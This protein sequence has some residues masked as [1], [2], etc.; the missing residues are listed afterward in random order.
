MPDRHLTF[1]IATR[2]RDGVIGVTTAIWFNNRLGRIYLRVVLP[3]HIL[4]TRQIAAQIAH[5]L[6]RRL[7]EFTQG[8]PT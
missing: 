8:V 4:A 6:T 7:G 3:G 2:I 1:T 5:P